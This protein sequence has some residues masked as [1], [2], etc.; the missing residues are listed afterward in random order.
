MKCTYLPFHRHIVS[1]SHQCSMIGPL[2]Y[3]NAFL[4]ILIDSCHSN[5]IDRHHR[6]IL[7]SSHQCNMIGQLVSPAVCIVIDSCHSHRIDRHHRHI[8]GSSLQC[9]MIGPLH[10]NRFCIVIDSCRHYLIYRRTSIRIHLDTAP[11]A[12]RFLHIPCCIAL[13]CNFYSHL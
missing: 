8:L 12:D 4:H 3:I 13:M 6:H 9:N 1:S 7:S 10:L 5:V 11:L 2:V